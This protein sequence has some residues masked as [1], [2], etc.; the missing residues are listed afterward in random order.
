MNMNPLAD[1]ELEYHGPVLVASVRGEVDLS[2]VDE[3]RALVVAAEGRR[4]APPTG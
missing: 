1:V 3:I 4:L 2:N